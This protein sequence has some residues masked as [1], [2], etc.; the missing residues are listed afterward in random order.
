MKRQNQSELTEFILT[1][2]S[3]L[4]DLQILLFFVFLL[5]YLTTL[6]AN[7]TIR[8]VIRLD[9]A[10][11]TPMYF[12]LFVLSCSETC[13]TLVIVPKMLTN[14]L[15]TIPTIS[16]FGCA[17][18]LYLFVGLA[19]TN[20]FLIAVMGYD[21]YVAIC[22][23]LTYTLIVSRA[24]C[25]QLVLASS[26]CGFLISM[27]VNILVF[28]VPFCD[29]NRINHFFCDISPV[30]KLGCTD[31]NLK[32][33]IIF[34]LSILVLLVPLALIFI[35]YVFI[36]STILKISSVEGQ[37]KA[38]A[39]CASHLTVVIVHYDC[40]SFIY[41][42]PTSLYSSDKDR[43]VAVTYTVIT[44]LLNPLVYTLRNKEVKTALRKVLSRYSYSKTV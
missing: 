35:S 44:P 13:Y 17:V 10:L 22:N 42:R 12:F 23:P 18:Q 5:V 15:S 30:T 7:T 27:I 14:L 26:F 4:G 41:L 25:M 31:T 38:F 39:T 40:A 3:E 32:E 24:T 1:G 11:H 8:T 21:R 34:F 29:S 20:C 37:C 6:M 19:C 16:F 33:M 9:R 36:V 43:L 28:T 2:F